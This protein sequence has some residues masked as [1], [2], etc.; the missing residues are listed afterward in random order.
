MGKEVTGDQIE[1]MMRL[2]SGMCSRDALSTDGRAFRSALNEIENLRELFFQ[3]A[4]L[5]EEQGAMV[6]NIEANVFATQEFIG[7][8]TTEIKKAVKY[9]KKHPCR[10]LF[11]C[12]FPCCNK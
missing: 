5:V 6:N 12:C 7:K 3:L 10:Q 2:G 9:K 11:C 8:A 1:D 4:L